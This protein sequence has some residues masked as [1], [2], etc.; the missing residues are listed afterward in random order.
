MVVTGVD[1]DPVKPGGEWRSWPEPP[2]CKVGLE[3]NFLC[4]VL[5]VLPAPQKAADD[6]EDQPLMQPDQRLEGSLVPLLRLRGGPY[7]LAGKGPIPPT[8]I[9]SLRSQSWGVIGCRGRT[10]TCNYLI[11]NQGIYQLI[12]PAIHILYTVTTVKYP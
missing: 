9:A 10:R 2:D 5:H 6:P 1:R 11:Q 7:A 3:K 8:K 4:Q 12:Y